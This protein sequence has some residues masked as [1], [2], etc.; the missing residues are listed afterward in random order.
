MCVSLGETEV[1]RVEC[2]GQEEQYTDIYVPN[3]NW[4][5]IGWKNGINIEKLNYFLKNNLHNNSII[6][7][8][9]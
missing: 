7:Q 9:I 4:P 8:D 2:I 3:S 6:K 5:L 1:A